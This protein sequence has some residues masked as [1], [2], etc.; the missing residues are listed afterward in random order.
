MRAC[1][2]LYLTVWG[3]LDSTNVPNKQL[4]AYT[5]IFF[6]DLTPQTYKYLRFDPVVAAKQVGYTPYLKL[7]NNDA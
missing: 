4:Y 2:R 1:I 6:G 7:A 3:N 5:S